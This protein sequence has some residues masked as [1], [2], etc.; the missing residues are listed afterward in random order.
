MSLVQTENLTKVYGTGQTAVTALNNLNLGINQGEFV[1]VMGPSGCGKSTLL[2]LIGGLDTPT[3]GHVTID[4]HKLSGLDDNH[5]TELRRRHIGFVFQFFN[6]IPVLT[7]TENAAL[8]LV[9]DGTKPAEANRKAK[10]WL[11]R[12]GLADKLDK[13][14]DQLSG[15]QQQRV[16]IARALTMEPEVILFDEPTSA[17]DPELVGEVLKVMRALTE[18]G[19]TMVVVTHE[20]GFAREVSNH[21]IFL[22]KGVIEEQG[23]PKKVLVHP[24]CERLQQFLSGNLK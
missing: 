15:G 8:P 2:H 12:L 4:G 21:V 17:L 23:D 11:E 6:L 19:R 20:M 10:A 13:R 1:A 18:E 5:L 9:L 22:H 7:A 24:E 14:P 3:K 16:A